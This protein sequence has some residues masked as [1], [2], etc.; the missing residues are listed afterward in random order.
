[1]KRR[2]Q[3]NYNV[4]AGGK[5][6]AEK[7][8]ENP[9]H[10][11]L[12]NGFIDSLL[13]LVQKSGKRKIF[14]IGCG[15]GQLIGVLDQE[16]YDVAGIDLDKEAVEISCENFAQI[17]RG[18]VSVT[19]GDLYDL[20][21]EDERLRNCM[22]ICCEVLEHVPDPEKALKIISHCTEDYFI[23]S[24]PHEPLWCML[25]ILR[26]KYLKSFGNTPGHINHWTKREFLKTV[27]KYGEILAVNTPLPWIM[28]LA[29][30][31]N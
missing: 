27:S 18:G 20:K 3:S 7:Y 5:H 13:L 6:H 1:M 22:L 16:G 14:E 23:V 31:H 12:I 28:A 10:K 11:W 17:G 24:V 21:E 30:K 26:G 8:N 19:L 25:N 29:K 9:I 4:F 2:I 15:E